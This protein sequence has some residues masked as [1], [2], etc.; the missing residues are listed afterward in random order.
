MKRLLLQSDD[1]GIT[2]GVSAGILQAVRNGMIRNTG[3]FVNMKSSATAAEQIKDVDVCLGIDIN[4][5]AGKP[6]TAP[7]K[8]PH[9]VDDTGAFRKLGRIL[10][11]NRVEY[12]DGIIYH[13]AEDPYPYEEILLE[14]ENQVKQFEKLTGK[15][16]EYLHPHSICT[17]NT[18]RAASEVAHKYNILHSTDMM[19]HPNYHSLPGAISL[20]KGSSLEE[21]LAQ[22]VEMEF[23]TQSL[24]SLRE[25]E[26]GYYIFHCGYV[27]CELMQV[28]SLNLKRMLDLQAATSDRVKSYIQEHDIELITYRDIK[29]ELL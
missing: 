26:T 24:P 22:N 10:K 9:L 18:E 4:Y 6:V 3:L 27:D 17:P 28:S 12:I 1:Y 13:F 15:L 20:K 2:E 19:N 21:Q 5:V 29:G 8:I 25:N 11:E 23:L 7:E 16:P 14:T